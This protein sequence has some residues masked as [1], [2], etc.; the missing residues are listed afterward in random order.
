MATG[1]VE[2]GLPLVS[3]SDT[4]Q[5]IGVV[6]IEFCF[7]FACWSWSKNGGHQWERVLVLDGDVVQWTVI[8]AGS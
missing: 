8:D 1:G 6:K 3:L 2:T 5:M 7:A 4:N